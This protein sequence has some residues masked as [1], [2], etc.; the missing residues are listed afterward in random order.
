MNYPRISRLDPAAYANSDECFHLT[1][2][3]HPKFHVW[4]IA[5]R[6]LIWGMTYGQREDDRIKLFAAC[7]MPDHLHLLA[8]PS[9][10]DI[11]TFVN[12]FK[13]Y[14]TRKSWELGNRN[15]LWQ[16]RTW[17]RSIR[18]DA[19]FVAVAEYIVRNPVSA[20]FVESETAWPHSWAWWWEG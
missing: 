13:S 1:L 2:N 3:A 7:L 4:P 5:L 6:E 8:S 12:A 14:S 16:P 11:M 18:S 20:G 10:T 9:R 19:D 17:D 15:A